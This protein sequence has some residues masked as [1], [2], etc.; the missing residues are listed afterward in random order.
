MFTVVGPRFSGCCRQWTP[1]FV[2]VSYRKHTL[3]DGVAFHRRVMPNALLSNAR[4]VVSFSCSQS[5]RQTIPKCRDFLPTLYQG[6][7][8]EYFIFQ[9][10]MC[11]IICCLEL[12]D[13]LNKSLFRQ[14]FEDWR[15]DRKIWNSYQEIQM[16][17][18]KLYIFI[19]WIR[20]LF[21]IFICNVHIIRCL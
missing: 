5:K 7:Y 18:C 2:I 21:V 10:K 4:L 19:K 3:R 12:R 8:L 17:F 16:F 20:C 9:T 1:I 6:N 15:I 14:S 13:L 11:E